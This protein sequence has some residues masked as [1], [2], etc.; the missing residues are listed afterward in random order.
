MTPTAKTKQNQ[1][2]NTHTTTNQASNQSTSRQR[3][4]ALRQVSQAL[5]SQER[6]GLPKDHLS[7]LASSRMYA[8]SLRDMTHRTSCS[9]AVTKKATARVLNHVLIDSTLDSSSLFSSR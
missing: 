7:S 2:E 8:T 9:A 4:N 3:T 5:F 1:P 6:E